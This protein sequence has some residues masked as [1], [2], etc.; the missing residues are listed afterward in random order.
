MLASDLNLTISVFFF[1]QALKR[2]PALTV[3]CGRS[4]TLV[5]TKSGAVFGFGFSGEF[6][7]G[8]ESPADGAAENCFTSPVKIPNL[9]E[10]EYKTVCAGEERDDDDEQK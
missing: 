1:N 6:Q 9:P 7:L 4:H 5:A 2:E 3:A 10:T 8:P